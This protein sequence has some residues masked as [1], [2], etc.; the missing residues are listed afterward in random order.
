MNIFDRIVQ[1]FEEGPPDSWQDAL[2]NAAFLFEKATLL[3]G[4]KGAME[5]ATSKGWPREVMEQ[6]TPPQQIHRLCE[7][8]IRFVERNL[9]HSAVG[10]AVFALGKALE[11]GARPV[12]DR[13]LEHHLERDGAAL[14]QALIALDNLGVLLPGS[15][16]HWSISETQHN[17]D[18]ASRYLAQKQRPPHRG[19]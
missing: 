11:P 6:A 1:A 18:V 12:F 10:P 13:V 7:A 8:L 2:L 5:F 14:Y 4:G 16:G 17:Q 9:D 3:R 15:T 19:H